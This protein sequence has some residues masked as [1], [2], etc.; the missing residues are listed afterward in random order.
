M[1]KD[2][3]TLTALEQAKLVRN[4]EISP[5]ELTEATIARIEA[6]NPQLNAYCTTAFDRARRDAKIAEEEILRGAPRGALHGVPF[7]AKDLISTAGVR[8]TYGSNVYANLVPEEDDIAVTRVLESGGILL[9]K[10]NTPEFGYQAACES[11]IF[12]AS[13]NPWSPGLTTG[14]SSGGS[15]AA[16]AAGLGAIS[17]GSD[18][19]GSLRIPASLCGIVA[20]KPTFGLVPVYPSARDPSLPGGS[21]WETLDHIGPMSRSVSDAALLLSVIAG[22]DGRDRHSAPTSFKF[23]RELLDRGIQDLR[24]AFTPDWGWANVDPETRRVFEEAVSVFAGQLDADLEE[25]FPPITYTQ[26]D[27]WKLVASEADLGGLRA[28]VEEHGSKMSQSVRDLV[29]TPWTA[30]DFT[31]AKRERQHVTNVLNK[32]FME[33]DLLI[34]PTVA[35][36]AFPLGSLG[37]DQ[38][39][40]VPVKDNAWIAFTHPFNLSGQPAISVP[41]GF[42]QEGLPVGLQIAGRRFEDLRV[43]QA[44]RAFEVARPWDKIWPAL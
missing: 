27:F 32:F 4:R 38:I 8:T 12:G 20:L 14:G 34:T 44:A 3:T 29:R 28:L 19:G 13:R 36:P 5:R 21:S 15:A 30:T 41:A 6:L 10:T 17:L 26:D 35:V 9:G 39:G 2:P 7:S 31:D 40:G 11:P 1:T 37:P 18:G 33:Y 16:V 24:L 23:D 43:L 25:S 22:F 42:T